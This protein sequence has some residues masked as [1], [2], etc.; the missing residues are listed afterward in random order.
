VARPRAFLKTILKLLNKRAMTSRDIERKTKK[1]RKVVTQNLKTALSED[2]AYQDG[3]EKYHLTTLGRSAFNNYVER[4]VDKVS[5]Q[6]PSLTMDDISWRQQRPVAICTLLIKNAEKIKE[7][8]EQTVHDRRYGLE[9]PENATAIKSSL[10]RIVDS[11]LETVGKDKGLGLYTVRDGQL[12]ESLS[13][14]NIQQQFP[15]YDFLKRYRKLADT[16]FEIV[17]KFNGKKWIR[18]Q[19]FKDVRKLISD[20]QRLY[21]ESM[22][23]ILSRERHKRINEALQRLADYNDWNKTKDSV[24]WSHLFENEEDLTKYLCQNFI[25]YGEKNN[26]MEIV[27]KAF[28]SGIFQKQEKTLTYLTLNPE[29]KKIEQFYNLLDN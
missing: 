15:G 25:F 18:T 1:S 4:P 20:S 27:N 2:L 6:I 14:F 11:V 19:R 17:I 29:P 28:E 7:L 23:Q 24:K 10:A 13:G 8:D 9:L 21:N 22:K 26:P 16:T 3:L 12:A 5:W